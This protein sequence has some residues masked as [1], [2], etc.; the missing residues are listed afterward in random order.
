MT[1]AREIHLKQRPHGEPRLGDFEL[2]E[3]ELPDPGDGELLV[4][5]TWMSVDPYMR[6]RMNDVKSYVPPFEVGAALEGGAVGEVVASGDERYAPG[7]RV[8]HGFGWRDHA[9]L[10]AKRVQKIDTTVVPEQ[11]YLGVL[12]MPGLTA[13]AG[14]VEVAPV[15]D[16][17]V[18]LI[19]AAAGAVGSAATQIARLL[20]ASRVIGIAGGPE[21]C[22]YVTE[23]LGANTAIDYKAGKVGA[24][25]RAIAPDG[26]DVFFDNVGGEQ[27]EAAIGSLR[28]HGRVA[29]CG[30]ISGYN[31]TEAQPG[32]RNMWRLIGIRAQLRGMIVTD[33]AH[34]RDRFIEQVGGWLASGALRYRETVVDGLDAAP[35]AFID[36]LR[37]ANTGKMLVRVG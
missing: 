20:G 12:G 3:T 28:L 29:L 26:I 30:A 9:L 2:V 19:S 8:L 5:N 11:A 15:R 32:P 31:A 1:T 34:L 6:G 23:E 13:Y 21:K 10:P 27:L 4:R 25:L 24:Q 16:G 7:D 22:A 35:Q 18:V 36:L 33:H 14:L 37:G 17:D